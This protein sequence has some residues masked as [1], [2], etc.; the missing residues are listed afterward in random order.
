MFVRWIKKQS[1]WDISKWNLFGLFLCIFG[2]YT[3]L[4]FAYFLL[5]TSPNTMYLAIPLGFLFYILEIYLDGLDGDIREVSEAT[6]AALDP[7]Q[8]YY[9]EVAGK[10]KRQVKVGM[11]WRDIADKRRNK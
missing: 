2:G 4:M 7:S 1:I 3:L 8:E 9:I 5:G 11:V 10:I 6:K